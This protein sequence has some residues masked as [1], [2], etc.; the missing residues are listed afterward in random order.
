VAEAAG[1]A[2][3]FQR[4]GVKIGNNVFI[5]LD[6]VSPTDLHNP[7]LL[8]NIYLG[9]FKHIM[10][11]VEGF[12]KKHKRQQVFDHA[13]K[14]IPPYPGFSVPKKAYREITQ[15][16]GKEMRNLG[17]CISAILASAFRIPDRSQ[18]HDFKSALKCVSA[19]VDFSLMAQYRSHTPD[20]LSYMESY[21]QTFH[22][23]KDI[24]LEF[25][26]SKATRTRA[27]RQDRELRKV[28]ADQRAKEVHHR[29]GANRRRQADQ[30]RVERS[31][32]PA[33]LIRR[34][35]HFNFIKMHYLTH[36]ASHVRRCGSIS[37]YSTEIGELAH[38]DQIKHGYRRS[39]KNDAAQQILSQYGRQHALGMRLQTIE[40]VSKVKGVIVA[41]DSGM[42]MPAV[43]SDSTPRRVLKGRMKNT[44]MLTILCA[45]LNIH[46]SDMMQEIL[47]FT[48]RQT[49]A[50]DRRLPADPTE[51]GLLPVEGF[52]QLEIPVADVEETDR[53]QIH[54]ARSTGTKA[55]RN[56]GPRNDWGWVQTGGEANYEDSRGRVVA[57]LLALFKIRN[58]LSEAGAVHRLQ[59]LAYSIRSIVADFT[60][61]A[62][63]VESAG[64]SMVESCE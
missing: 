9:L 63:I 64:G 59:W 51:L 30:E 10:E 16:Q 60:L 49:A 42:E 12:L 19:L 8:H 27:D 6:R 40:A 47:R 38:K 22:R 58:I 43:S 37:M 26:T 4:L 20:T 50:D 33:D 52:A 34:E 54:R 41:E 55:F 14:E 35:N 25:S 7:D 21:L 1:I 53:F 18:Y 17:H 44:S 45:T 28:M 11:W 5:G 62:D 57:R 32:R 39:N 46:Y 2:K 61:R 29:T 3:Y 24:F 36:F 13:W 15:W 23:T 48:T 56:G 31:D